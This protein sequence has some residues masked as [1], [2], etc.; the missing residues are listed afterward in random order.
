MGISDSSIFSSIAD[1]LPLAAAIVCAGLAAGSPGRAQTTTATPDKAPD[2]ALSKSAEGFWMHGGLGLRQG[3]TQAEVVSQLKNSGRLCS[4]KLDHASHDPGIFAITACGKPE[5]YV[6]F[7]KDRL[8][9]ASTSAKGGFSAF[10]DA[11]RIYSSSALLGAGFKAGEITALSPVR[12]DGETVQDYEIS[13]QMTGPKYAV[14]MTMFAKPDDNKS[15]ADEIR[16]D[17]QALVDTAD[18]R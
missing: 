5:A 14:T 10:V 3:Q 2:D 8:Y 1:R 7:C 18:C 15:V 16:I 12:R 17:Y 13:I 9:W 4:M 11:M 6:S